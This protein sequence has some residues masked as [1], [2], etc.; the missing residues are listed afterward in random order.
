[1]TNPSSVARLAARASSTIAPM[2]LV[3]ATLLL[4]EAVLDNLFTISINDPGAEEA[5]PNDLVEAAGVSLLNTFSTD[6]A[7]F[8][9]I[10]F[11]DLAL[12][13]NAGV[14][15]MLLVDRALLKLGGMSSALV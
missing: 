9:T 12:C 4:D 8:V 5:L 1:M 10:L 13:V 14:D 7:G 6:P 15:T 2:L 11:T 3:E